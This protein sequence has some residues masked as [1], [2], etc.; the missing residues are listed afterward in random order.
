VQGSENAGGMKITGHN[1]VGGIAGSNAGIIEDCIVRNARN[2][3]TGY[4]YVG[5]IAGIAELDNLTIINPTVINVKLAS[6]GPN[7]G[8][9][10]GA[11]GVID[12]NITIGYIESPRLD[13]RAAIGEVEE[14]QL[15]DRIN[16]L[17]NTMANNED[18]LIGLDI[19]GARFIYQTAINTAK[20]AAEIVLAEPNETG[21]IK[22]AIVNLNA[23]TEIF[24][25]FLELLDASKIYYIVLPADLPDG[26][27][28]VSVSVKDGIECECA[29]TCANVDADDIYTDRSVG[30]KEITITFVVDIDEFDLTD[31]ILVITI[32]REDGDAPIEIKRNKNEVEALILLFGAL[33]EDEFEI[34][35]TMPNSN[36]TITVEIEDTGVLGALAGYDGMLMPGLLPVAAAG[37]R[38]AGFFRGKG[39]KVGRYARKK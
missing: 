21:V 30:G 20:A 15:L 22:T 1:N 37:K 17:D 4:D 38:G 24:E 19:D 9:I 27:T 16:G 3:I 8:A 25:K 2:S 18:F 14:L 23:A 13:L 11:N 26:I 31:K 7:I 36:I 28:S 6:N 12:G 10:A 39:K 35:F 33:G 32:E 5:G 29:T 34:K